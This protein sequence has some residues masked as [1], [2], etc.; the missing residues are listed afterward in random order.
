MSAAVLNDVMERALPGVGLAGRHVVHGWRATF[1]TLCNEA[2]PGA[3]RVIDVMLAHKAF[4]EVEARYNK[5]TFIAERRKLASAWADQVLA[6]APSASALVG[7]VEADM[8]N[9]V[10]MRRAA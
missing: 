8:T 4:G 6:G 1:S 3:Y 9:V 5:A 7:L 2:D 10:E